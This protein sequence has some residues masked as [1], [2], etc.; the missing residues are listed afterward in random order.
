MGRCWLITICLVGV[1]VLGLSGQSIRA[2]D[3]T[4]E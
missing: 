2:E 1:G 4:P 3:P